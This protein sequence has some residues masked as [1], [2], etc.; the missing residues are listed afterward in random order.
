MIEEN[1]IV[2]LF[3]SF[4]TFILFDNILSPINNKVVPPNIPTNNTIIG[5][6]LRFSAIYMD[7][8]ISEKKLAAIIIPA[9]KLKNISKIVLL[10]FLNKN[11]LAEPSEVITN[12]NIQPIKACIAGLKLEKSSII[13]YPPILLN[14]KL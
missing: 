12:V 5:V 9:L 3:L 13:K 6:K 11:T 8:N 7:G 10:N 2:I 14:D 1:N 4:D